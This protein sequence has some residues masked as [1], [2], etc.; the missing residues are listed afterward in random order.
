MATSAA[1]SA[2]GTATVP[3]RHRAWRAH[4]KTQLTQDEFDACPHDAPAASPKATSLD[5]RC[6]VV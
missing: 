2:V 3:M 5:G 4:R 6:G 1:A